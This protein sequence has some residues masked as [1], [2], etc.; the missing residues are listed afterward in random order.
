MV[1]LLA[2]VSSAPV[3]SIWAASVLR[4]SLEWRGLPAPSGPSDHAAEI[5]AGEVRI[6]V[7]EHVGLDVAEGRLRLVLDAVI[8]GLDDVLL[9]MRSTGMCM[10]HRLALRVAVFGIGQAKYVHFDAGS[11]QSDDRV[12][13]LRDAR[14]RVQG[15]RGPDRIDIL[16]S[17]AVA[18][19]EVTGDIRA[20]DLEPLGWAAVLMGQA[21][22][23]EHRARIKQLGIESEPATL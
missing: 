2:P 1:K 16:L 6:L 19:E 8:E 23:V 17:D 15:D 14:R 7:R 4:F 22:V 11:H 18:S 21:H 20:V 5:A 10:D 12:H 9:E 3:R 13:V